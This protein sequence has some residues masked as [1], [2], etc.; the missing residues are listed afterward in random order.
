[1]YK[2]PVT[3]DSPQMDNYGNPAN[4]DLDRYY[5]VLDDN[6]NDVLSVQSFVFKNIFIRYPD[7]YSSS[8]S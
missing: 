5:A 8:P 3:A 1:M 7:F 2:K 6:L 4:Y